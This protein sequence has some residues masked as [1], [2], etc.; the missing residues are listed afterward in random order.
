MNA[1]L[2]ILK[3]ALVI[4]GLIAALSLTSCNTVAGLGRDIGS[5]G[6]GLEN[7]ASR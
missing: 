6:S 4:T 2:T 5:A 7:A 1:I 3:A